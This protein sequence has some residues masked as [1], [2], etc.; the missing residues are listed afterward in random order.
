MIKKIN[1]SNIIDFFSIGHSK[2]HM[3]FILCFYIDKFLMQE[4]ESN[5]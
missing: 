5:Q 1:N 4:Q 3:H 2:I